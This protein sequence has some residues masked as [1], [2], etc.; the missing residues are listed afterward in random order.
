V[1]T[2]GWEERIFLVDGGCEDTWGIGEIGGGWFMEH[3][4]KKL[5]DGADSYFWTD[6]WLG[7]VPLRERFDRLFE[8]AETQSCTVAAMSALG[9]E[10]GGGA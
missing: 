1:P 6:L 7:G 3:I 8:L 4:S 2:R 5:E 10:A 9:W